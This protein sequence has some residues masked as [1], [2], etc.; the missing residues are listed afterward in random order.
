MTDMEQ[1]VARLEESVFFQERLIADLNAA[2]TAQQRQLDEL[3]REAEWLR[4][5]LKAALEALGSEG[6][7]NVPPPHYA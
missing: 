3:G 5:R 7:A 4:P 2:L 6:P 1:R